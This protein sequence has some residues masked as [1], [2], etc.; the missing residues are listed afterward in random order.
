MIK[1]KVSEIMKIATATVLSI[2]IFSMAFI[3]VNGV[4]F[5]AATYGTQDIPSI[6]ETVNIPENLPP[7][8]FQLPAITVLEEVSDAERN[9]HALTTEEAAELGAQY[10]W[11]VFGESID[12]KTVIMSYRNWQGMTRTYWQGVVMSN[13]GAELLDNKDLLSGLVYHR[14]EMTDLT[15]G[16]IIDESSFVFSSREASSDG[17]VYATVRFVASGEAAEINSRHINVRTVIADAVSGEEINTGEGLFM[18]L[19]DAGTGERIDITSVW[20]TNSRNLTEEDMEKSMA[21]REIMSRE[22]MAGNHTPY[23][24]SEEM[25]QFEMCEEVIKEYAQRHFNNS[26]VVNIELE[27]VWGSD[28]IIDSNE[29]LIATDKTLR[30]AVT[31]DTGRVAMISVHAKSNQVIGINTQLNDIIPGFFDNMSGRG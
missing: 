27:S 13:S 9:A 10:I 22:F 19:I 1:H 24:L 5:A 11:E 17:T 31:D 8:N 23:T 26:T 20:G 28:F 4:A 30:F 7:A 29:N 25:K 21:I 12:N 16:K 2:G 3:G 6:T 15:S 14:F 18:F